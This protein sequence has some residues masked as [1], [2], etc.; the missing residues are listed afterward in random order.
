[1]GYKSV[2]CAPSGVM[3]GALGPGLVQLVGAGPGDPELLTLKALRAI[4][5][6]EV[7]VFDRLVSEEILSLIPEATRRIDV[8]KTPHHH[9]V[10]QEEIQERL[11]ALARQGL[12]VVRLKG[13]DPFVF[14]RGGE[15]AIA[16]AAAGINV[17]VVPGITSAQGAAACLKMPLTHRALASGVRLIAGHRQGDGMLDYDWDGLADSKTTLVIYMAL[18][19]IAEIAD[20]L[21]A[22]GRSSGT[23]VLAIARATCSD[24]RRIMA[25]LETISHEVTRSKIKAP[26]LFM[27]GEVVAIAQFMEREAFADP[28]A[29]TID[30]GAPTAVAAE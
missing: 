25:T 7:V 22:H 19:N 30:E 12:R 18:A 24:E 23:P 13:G 3:Q 9:P 10:P 11:V 1:M 29:E 21:M 8:G 15:E 2:V 4:E 6:A 14:G 16:L 5:N 20:K 27:I 17:E 26:V 28:A